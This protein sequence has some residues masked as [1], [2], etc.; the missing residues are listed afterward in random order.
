M[1]KVTKDILPRQHLHNK[2]K[3][4]F[5][6]QNCSAMDFL[7][8]MPRFQ[9]VIH[10]HQQMDCLQELNSFP[11]GQGYQSLFDLEITHTVMQVIEDKQQDVLSWHYFQLSTDGSISVAN[12]S[13]VKLYHSAIQKY[14]QISCC[15][16]N[17]TEIIN[18]QL[19]DI[20]KTSMKT[21]FM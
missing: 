18:I 11:T 10:Y 8:P 14:A 9:L 19:K 5:R 12:N 20:Q 6:N 2:N 3:K 21:N 16:R 7:H 17:I 13:A 4:A 15:N 1:V